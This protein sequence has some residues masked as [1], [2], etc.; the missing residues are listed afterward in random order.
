M[1]SDTARFLHAWHTGDDETVID[2]LRQSNIDAMLA[3]FQDKLDAIAEE[4]E[5]NALEMSD[6]D[7]WEAVDV[8]L[9]TGNLAAVDFVNSVSAKRYN[10][11]H[12]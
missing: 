7:W 10:S 1:M 3:K 5:Q 2:I 8:V 12:R 9:E 4:I 6:E 11:N